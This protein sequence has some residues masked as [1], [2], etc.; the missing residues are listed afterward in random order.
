MECAAEIVIN[1]AQVRSKSA[2]QD[3]RFYVVIARTGHDSDGCTHRVGYNAQ[4]ILRR[5]LFRVSY[6]SEEVTDLTIAE[7]DRCA[8][9]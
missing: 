1:H 9:F 7:R 2:I 3:Q 8:D 6:R 5:T 4:V